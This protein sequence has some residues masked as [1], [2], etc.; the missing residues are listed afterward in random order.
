MYM[1][2][3]GH[4]EVVHENMTCPVCEAIE[5]KN[6]AIEASSREIEDKDEKI[7]ALEDEIRS[8]KVGGN[9]GGRARD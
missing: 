1:C 8:L 2:S 6:I 9:D 4:D 7:G 3:S 5:D